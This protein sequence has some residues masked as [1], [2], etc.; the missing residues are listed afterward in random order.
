F[1]LVRNAAE[2]IGDT[3][4]GR[5]RVECGLRHCDAEVLSQAVLGEDCAQ[6]AYVYIRVTDDGCGMS[7]ATRRKSFDP[8]FTTKFTGRGLS[9]SAVLGIVRAYRGFITC[10]S[11]LGQGTSIAVFFPP[12]TP[13]TESNCTRCDR[14]TKLGHRALRKYSDVLNVVCQTAAV[15]SESEYQRALASAISAHRRASELNA[16]LQYHL[17]SVH[18][19]PGRSYVQ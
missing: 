2:A 13:S 11:E 4:R 7:E 14:L 17:R 18:Q 1:S 9:L 16:E 12:A 8:F 10:S 5:I 3:N 15:A 19:L 6:G